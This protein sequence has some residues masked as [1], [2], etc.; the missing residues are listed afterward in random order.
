MIRHLGASKHL[1]NRLGFP[2]T[3]RYDL[4][5]KLK[6][7]GTAIGINIWYLHA[8]LAHLAEM[9]VTL[10]RGRGYERVCQLCD[11]PVL[12]GQFYRTKHRQD[13]PVDSRKLLSVEGG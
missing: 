2:K 4:I 10:A 13:M 9:P 1:A 6:V 5:G 3:R 8:S 12:P 11:Q 7:C